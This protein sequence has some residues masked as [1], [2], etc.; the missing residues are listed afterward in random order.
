MAR[1]R[2]AVASL[3]K[4]LLHILDRLGHEPVSSVSAAGSRP[5]ARCTPAGVGR[6]VGGVTRRVPK[7]DGLPTCSD[8]GPHSR[9][10]P[11]PKAKP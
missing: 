9:A 10:Y 1:D 2:C 5:S 4:L 6:L 8:E 11:P 3:G 7:P